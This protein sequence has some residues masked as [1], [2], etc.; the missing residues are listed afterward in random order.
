MQVRL[1]ADDRVDG[2]GGKA[3]RA[4]DAAFRIDSGDWRIDARWRLGDR[5]PQQRG[6]R[7]HRFRAAGWAAIDGPAGGNGFGIGTAARITALC[8]LG[9]GQQLVDR[10]HQWVR[11]ARK[12]AVGPCEQYGSHRAYDPERQDDAEHQRPT[13]AK[14]MKPKARIPAL[15][16]AIG[17]PAKADGT[18]ARDNRSRSAAKRL[19]TSAKPTPAPTL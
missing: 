14:P 13:P 11:V 19:I 2:A 8:A 6:E 16:S 18:A 15:T 17:M 9:L 10:P 3:K 5:A 1:R 4:A 12:A 7:R